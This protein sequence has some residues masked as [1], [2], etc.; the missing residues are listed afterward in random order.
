VTAVVNALTIDVET[1]TSNKGNPFDQTNKLCY[2]G[3]PGYCYSIEYDSSPFR[4]NLSAIQ[5]AIND[6]DL[7]VGFNIK[8][9]LHWIKK[10]GLDFSTKRIWDCQIAH[11]IITGQKH[12]YPSLN[13]VAEYYGLGTKLDEVKEVYWKNGIDTP[14]IP[15][16][17]LEEYLTQ[18]IDLTHKVYLKQMEYLKDKSLLARLISL[19]NQDLLVLQEMEFNGLVFDESESLQLAKE[20]NVT[21]EELN[22]ILYSYHNC[23]G[24]NPNSN[25]HVSCLLY[26]GN[27]KLN[28]RVAI[29]HFKTGPRAG[30]VKEK[31]EEYLVALPRLVKPLKGSE[32]AKE[33]FYATNEQ[34]LKSLRGNKKAK[35]II[36]L[37]LKI[38]ELNKRVGTYYQGL[39]N[40]RQ[41]NNWPVGKVHGQLNQC[42]ASTGRL[43]SSKP[44]LQNFDKEIKI[45]FK[46]RFDKGGMYA[47]SS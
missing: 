35:E 19:H 31:W 46:S 41:K 44:N 6:C 39:P 15:R 29:G 18:D 4:D 32:L 9:D 5:T 37:L 8:F 3:I 11:F 16:E 23:D 24:F 12:R 42:V 33:G 14:D 40:L 10:Y 25:D 22:S 34:T 45:L 28:R 38:S 30:E 43:S 21:I 26:G 13:D 7:L 47:N 20:T 27:V 17:I 36:G 1:T 2:I